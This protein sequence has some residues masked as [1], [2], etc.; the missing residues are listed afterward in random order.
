MV[1][2]LPPPT[3]TSRADEPPRRRRGLGYQPALDG[4]RA[5]S[6]LAVL[7]YHADVAWIP[8]G[9]LGVEVFF[10]ISGFLITTLLIEEWQRS[11]AIDRP[12]FW[13]RRAR[14]LLPALFGVLAVVTIYTAVVLPDELARLRGDVIAALTYTTN[15]FLIFSQQ[16]YFEAFGRQSPLK[17]LW[18]LA[19]EEQ[20]YIVWPI[21]FGFAIKK[22]GGKAGRLFGPLVLGAIAS[23]ALMWLMYN[24]DGD[25][26][27]VYYGTDTRAAGILLGGALACVWMPWRSRRPAAAN[28]GPLLE[29]VGGVALLGLIWFFLNTGEFDPWL[30]QGGFAIVSLT[31]VVVIAVIMHPS[32]RLLKGAFALPPLVWIGLRSYG[33]YLWHWPVFVFMTPDEVGFDGAPLFIAKFAVTFLL[34]ELSFRFIEMPI[35]KEGLA[36]VK[37]L[38]RV[39]TDGRRGAAAWMT[40][41]VLVA[42]TAL[43]IMTVAIGS[44]QRPPLLGEDEEQLAADGE[45]FGPGTQVTD[46]AIEGGVTTIVTT[47]APTANTTAAPSG[48]EA[49][50]PVPP[51]TTVPVGNPPSSVVVVGDSV[52]MTLVRNAPASARQAFTITDGAIEGCGIVEGSVKTT[53]RFRWSFNG[54]AGWPEKWASN[55]TKAGAQVALVTIGAWDVFDLGRD[56]GDLIFGTPAH[57]EHLRTQLQKGIDALKGA[58]VKVALLEVPC[59]RPVSAGGLTALPERGD[60]NRTRHLNDLLRQAAAADPANVVFITGPQQYCTDEAIAKDLGHRWDGVHYYKPGAQLVWDTIVPELQQLRV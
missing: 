14:R 22:V 30:Y 23:T 51:T 45:V 44:A 29:I 20:F 32:V 19:V 37:R 36:P 49:A 57:D 13:L 25:P 21:V 5:L 48:G 33:I 40:V 58:G 54:C 15:W 8:G 35:R 4:L 46:P 31:A 26:S 17:H 28:A 11:G 10:V 50:A 16:S 41:P 55:A 34:A 7:L 59:Y 47:V 39:G 3:P 52:G 42:V 1:T 27:R 53:A 2:T 60:D 56:S 9:F 24:P 18:S 43:G 6:V 38:L 12:R